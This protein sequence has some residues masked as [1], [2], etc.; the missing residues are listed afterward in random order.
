[1]LAAAVKRRLEVCETIG[2]LC[3][4]GAELFIAA[5]TAAI[6]RRGKFTVALSGGSTPRPLFSLLASDEYL[7]RV[8]WSRTHFFWVDERC[9]PPVHPDS[10]YKAAYDLLLA[11]LPVDSAHF[12]RIPGEQSPEAAAFSYEQNLKDFFADQSLPRFDLVILGVGTDGHTASIFPGSRDAIDTNRC[13]VAVYV[14]KMASYRVTLTLP[15]L[16]NAREVVFLVSGKEKA[17]VVRSILENDMQQ[18]PTSLVSPVE[19][20]VTWLLDNEAAGLLSE[21]KACQEHKPA[22]T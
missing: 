6:T 8:D 7:G 11:K 2:D 13:A 3:R 16:N 5:A 1:L 21:V 14:E 9:V 18:Y 12:N 4:K 19:G 20:T 17:D 10:N 22:K 15:V